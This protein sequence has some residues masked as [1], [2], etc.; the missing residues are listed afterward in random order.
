MYTKY[1]QK[2]AEA[3]EMSLSSAPQYPERLDRPTAPVGGAGSTRL[4]RSIRPTHVPMPILGVQLQ[5]QELQRSGLGGGGVQT[6]PGGQA[7]LPVPAP[8]LSSSSGLLYLHS[9]AE[10]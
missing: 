1:F 7:M 8:D 2:G 5:Q 9:I 4:V 6:I 10:I 3:V